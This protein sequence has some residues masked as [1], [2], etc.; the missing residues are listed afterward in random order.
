MRVDVSESGADLKQ[1]F[2]LQGASSEQLHRNDNPLDKDQR[3]AV[4]HGMRQE[5]GCRPAHHSGA[6]TKWKWFTNWGCDFNSDSEYLETLVE[7]DPEA[8][9]HPQSEVLEKFLYRATGPTMIKRDR[10]AGF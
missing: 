6:P 7:V 2:P 8:Q 4:R 1:F 5:A 9:D 3:Q 10:T